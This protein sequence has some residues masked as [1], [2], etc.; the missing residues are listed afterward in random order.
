MK[1][2]ILE[3]Q[4]N[5]QAQKFPCNVELPS[6]EIKIGSIRISSSNTILQINLP[7]IVFNGQDIAK[8]KEDPVHHHLNDVLKKSNTNEVELYTVSSSSSKNSLSNVKDEEVV[9]EARVCTSVDV[10]GL[11]ITPVVAEDKSPHTLSPALTSSP[12]PPEVSSHTSSSAPSVDK[13]PEQAK[14]CDNFN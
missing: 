2:Q 3:M 14:V 1:T 12:P 10:D 11:Y 13:K 7:Q 4:E 8:L 9:E 5:V 6:V